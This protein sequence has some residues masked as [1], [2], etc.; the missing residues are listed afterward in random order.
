MTNVADAVTSSNSTFDEVLRMFQDRLQQYKYMEVSKKQ[1]A[2]D[3]GV[4]IP[5]IQKNLET[6]R[7]I[8]ECKKSEDDDDDS[9]ISKSITTNFELNDTLYTEATIDVENLDSIYLWLGADVMLEYPLS[10]AVD[11]LQDRLEKN[12]T[13]LELIKE[14]LDFLKEN[15]TTMEV[16]TA[17]LYN[18]DVEQRKKSK[19]VDS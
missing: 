16:N 15:I 11:L 18:W 14:D 10:E 17:R 9:D 12:K 19:V 5:D 7:F 6:I 13:H 3:L 2:A 8:Q 4:K 1:Q